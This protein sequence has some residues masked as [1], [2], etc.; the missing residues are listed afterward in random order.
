MSLDLQSPLQGTVLIVDVEVGDK[1]SEGQRVALLESMKMEHEVLATSGGVITKVCIEIGQMVAE[2]EKLFSFDIREAPSSTEVTSDPVDLTYIRPDLAETIE[3]HEIGRDHRRKSAV[4]KRHL[5]GQRTARENIADLTDRGELIEYGPLTIAPQRKRRSVDDL[6]LNTP[7]DGMVGGLAEVN[8]DLFDESK[9]QCVVISYDY[10]VLAGTQGG[11][12]HRKKD[13]L[14]EI[15]KKWKLPVVFFTEGG[16]GRPGD[17]DGLQ[18][19]G[20]DCLAFGLWAEL[21][22]D[23]PLIGITS[24][25]CFAGNAAILGCCDVIIATEDANIGMGGPAMI[26]GGGLGT[27]HPSEVGPVE[28]QKSNGVVDIVVQ[29]EREA[30]QVAK[31]YLS[32]FQGEISDWGVQDQRTLR[33]LV[34]ENRLRAYDIRKV[35]DVLFDT[36]SLLELRKDFGIGIITMLARIEGKP[37]G[38]IANNPNHL[39]GAIDADAAD[40]AS[41]FMQLCDSY[42]LPIISLCDTPGFMVGPEAEKT[43]LVRHVSRMFVTARSVSVP[44]GTI[45]LRKAYGLGAQAMA[46]G[47]F[48]FPMFTISWPTGEF[49]GMGLEGA[50]KLGYKKELDAIDD[51]KERE[52]AYQKLV[53]RMYQVGKGLSMADHFEIDDV[54]DPQDSR[55]WIIAALRA[56]GSPPKRA[57]KKRPMIDTW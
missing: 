3:R 50:V 5:K 37:I 7:A 38:V 33:H 14:F 16:G 9:T 15:A 17:T 4:E 52:E 34:P 11:Q 30:V 55:Q 21:S 49:G 42:D 24:G 26:E 10:T 12:N 23:V 40:K 57:Q 29:D 51:L 2:S 32:Y 54:I 18:V 48:K 56:A 47:G 53:D 25:Y 39:G 19:A 44:T 35:I 43:A 8:S 20:L 45:V 41:R 22:G 46:S 13:R 28:V 6:I 1:I 27:Y 31:K 36:E